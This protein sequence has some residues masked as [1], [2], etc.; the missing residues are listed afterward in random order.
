MNVD[1]F[2]P[3][4][5]VD[6]IGKTIGK[7]HAGV[8]KRHNMAVSRC[9]TLPALVLS[10]GWA[11]EPPRDWT[12]HLHRVYVLERDHAAAKSQ[13]DWRRCLPA[14]HGIERDHAAA[15]AY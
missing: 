8:M 3:G 13:R 12:G 15:E 11:R 10:K 1:H 14:V 6:V 2:V 9:R 7:G 4:Q 5:Y